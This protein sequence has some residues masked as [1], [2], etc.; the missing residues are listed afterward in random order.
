MLPLNPADNTM[1][2]D[3]DNQETPQIVFQL[4]LVKLFH[5]KSAFHFTRRL[6]SLK[7]KSSLNSM[8]NFVICLLSPSKSRVRESNNVCSTRQTNGMSMYEAKG[9]RVFTST[10]YAPMQSRTRKDF[11]IQFTPVSIHKQLF[12]ALKTHQF[13]IKRICNC[14]HWET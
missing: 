3:A 13:L 12:S 9:F 8:G 1:L 4:R 7:S 14:K 10:T 6:F 11:F 5:F 2:I